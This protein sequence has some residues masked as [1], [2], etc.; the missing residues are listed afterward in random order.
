MKYN[1]ISTGSQGNAVVL[2]DYILIDCGVPFKA[3]KDVYRD[4]KI[5]LLTHEHYDHINRATIKRLAAE[6]PTLRFACCQWLVPIL[7]KCEV[8]EQNIDVL[9]IGEIYDYRAFKVSPIKLY[10]D[11]ENCGYRL[12][13]G[14]KKAIYATDT[15]HLD[16]ITAKGYDLYMIEANYTEEDL[17]RRIEAKKATGEFS[18]EQNCALRHLSHEQASQFLLENMRKDSE[19]VFL[20]GH[21]EKPSKAEEWD[22]AET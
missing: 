8:A 4:L 19:Y 18:Y 12:F 5:V 17:Q 6:R 1:I 15:Q 22:Y 14:D 9:E 20:H 21:K 2:N 11:V 13:F 16:G 10:H 3:L 7:V